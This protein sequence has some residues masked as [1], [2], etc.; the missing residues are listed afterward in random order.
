VTAISGVSASVGETAYMFY[1]H[2]RICRIEHKAVKMTGLVIS[3]DLAVKAGIALGSSIP[4]LPGI[5]G[6]VPRQSERLGIS[7][8]IWHNPPSRC[9]V[10]SGN[11]AFIGSI[12]QPLPRR[13]RATTSA[14]SGAE[15]ATS[16][17]LSD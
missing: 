16:N 14:G 2:R 9:L 10:S 12:G 4:A 17:P 3:P 5:T 1:G 7:T 15:P 13:E 6:F 8:G 11:C